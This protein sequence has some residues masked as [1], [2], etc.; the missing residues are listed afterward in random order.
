MTSPLF[1]LRPIANGYCQFVLRYFKFIGIDNYQ[2]GLSIVLLAALCGLAFLVNGRAR[3]VAGRLC[4]PWLYC[5]LLIFALFIIRLPTFLPGSSLNP[6]ESL[7]LAGAMKLRHDPVFWQSLD[8]ATSGPLNFYPLTL[9]NILG[10]P[11]DYATARLLNVICIGATI[12]VVYR[13]ARLFMDDWA[14]R[15]TPLPA[16]AAVM[17]FRGA[18]F[19]HYSS[20]CVSVLLIAVATWML[21]AE[22]IDGRVSWLR[23]AGIGALVAFIPLAKL[24]AA[25][26]AAT[27]ALGGI[28]PAF[29]RRKE[30]KWRRALYIAGG[31]AA[32]M[33]FLLLFL[34]VFGLFGTFQL[35]YVAS[36][37]LYA[38]V[39][40][41]M[42]FDSFLR[43]CF[44]PEIEWYEGGI[45]ACLVYLFVTS[46]YL[47]MRREGNRETSN[48]LLL[49]AGIATLL[50]CSGAWWLSVTSAIGWP[51][52][53]FA[54]L[55]GL[56]AGSIRRVVQSPA[57]IKRL[58]FYDLLAFSI[59]IASLYAV[60]RP[61]R[62]FPHYLV[63]LIFPLAF[64]GVRIFARLLRV[65]KPPAPSAGSNKPGRGKAVTPR[66]NP[67]AVRPAIVFVLLA[68]AVPCFI[69]SKSLK[70]AFQSEAWMTAPSAFPECAACQLVNHFAKPGDPVTVW[71]WAAEF[72][73]LT[74]T[75]PA[76]RDPG[77]YL[78]MRPGP[79]RDYYRSRFLEDLRR[80][81]P[82]L[83]VD[84]VAPGQFYYQNR[85]TDGYETFPDLRTYV[86][87][88]FN[89]EGD[90][91]GVRVF[92]RKD[93]AAR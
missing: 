43:F 35:S 21:L 86:T 32:V 89:L 76:T 72:H 16:L 12:A 79:L 77:M 27:I 83:F 46:Y 44:S 37:I 51:Q 1:G 90:V 59:L 65:A 45:L 38:D 75:I 29:F 88:N 39:L 68:L 61:A 55:I 22:E 28:A 33:T 66:P 64:V 4:P 70:L 69:R 20:E 30:Y 84:A 7:F 34:L 23:A 8:G 9:L 80:D 60:Y 14:A 3:A 49:T 36:N 54:I 5:L 17:A 78:Q 18:D 57:A 26:I 10:F 42:S 24:Q 91:G 58:S 81:P 31:M 11:F 85:S 71:G 6:D 87:S 82:K 50:Y 56:A 40:P 41:P 2:I 53:F 63:F 62:A 67:A 48:Q 92:A 47:W 73:V 52:V 13:I 93:V 25:P 15:L 74:G 19:I